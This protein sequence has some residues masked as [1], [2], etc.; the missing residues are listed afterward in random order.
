MG[1]AYSCFGGIAVGNDRWLDHRALPGSADWCSS[2]SRS[3][4]LRRD[5]RGNHLRCHC[6]ADRDCGF[7]HRQQP[8]VH[9]CGRHAGRN[10]CVR[11]CLGPGLAQSRAG[12]PV[13]R[14]CFRG[15]FDVSENS[16]AQFSKVVAVFFCK[17]GFARKGQAQPALALAA[18]YLCG[19]PR[20]S[21]RKAV[22]PTSRPSI[23]SFKRKTGAAE[24]LQ[25]L[26]LLSL[27]PCSGIAYLRARTQV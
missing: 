2:Y 13:T 27:S 3:I 17:C 15:P 7:E 12:Y 10:C 25:W 8:F 6:V 4:R 16:F 21:A 19:S 22:D 20:P 14:T 24:H 26:G 9:R 18:V 23:A 11:V 1:D 5:P